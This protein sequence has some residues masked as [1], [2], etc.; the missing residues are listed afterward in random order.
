MPPN[1]L[2]VPSEDAIGAGPAVQGQVQNAGRGKNTAVRGHL[3]TP[4][5]RGRA[6]LQALKDLRGRRR[7]KGLSTGRGSGR[8]CGTG[9]VQSSVNAAWSD[10]TEG[11]KISAKDLDSVRI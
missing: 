8:G 5:E 3:T 1:T 7:R 10:P 4:G 6:T 9:I 11:W 2:L